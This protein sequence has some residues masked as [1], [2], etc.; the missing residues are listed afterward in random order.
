MDD[1][2][3]TKRVSKELNVQIVSLGNDRFRLTNKFG[4]HKNFESSKQALKEDV[5]DILIEYGVNYF[6]KPK[7][8]KK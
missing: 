8:E 7:V 4:E 6:I 1:R 3:K 2:I 5:R